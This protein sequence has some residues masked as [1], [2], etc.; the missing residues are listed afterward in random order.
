MVLL[1]KKKENINS[2]KKA[3]MEFYKKH[4][5][6][7][8]NQ[9]IGFNEQINLLNN[10]CCI[11]IMD[12]K[13]NFKIGGGPIE[14]SRDFYNKKFISCFGVCLITKENDK[15]KRRY[16]NILSEIL[17]HDSLFVKDCIEMIV[18][19]ILK[20]RFKQVSFW[21]DNGKHF[22]SSELMKYFYDLAQKHFDF[23]SMNF[24]VEYL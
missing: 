13:Q 1:L 18:K 21:A 2:N 6:C 20:N 9:K 5:H 14:T 16:F 4:K 10:D 24:F 22:R 15:I 17:T 23:V 11:V 19:E 8:N 7:I 12:F 3:Y